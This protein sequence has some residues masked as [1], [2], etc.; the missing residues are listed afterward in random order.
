MKG[1]IVVEAVPNLAGWAKNRS[2]FLTVAICCNEGH[3][4]EETVQRVSSM[5]RVAW[6][7]SRRTP[8]YKCVGM[9]LL[10]LHPMR[11]P[12]LDPAAIT[13]EYILSVAGQKQAIGC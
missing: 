8:P 10:P 9:T 6:R 13:G 12:C 11:P 4:E 3:P 5:R 1:S 2:H 7:L